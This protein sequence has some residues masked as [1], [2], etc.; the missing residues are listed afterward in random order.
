MEIWT[1]FPKSEVL[2][3]SFRALKKNVSA[4]QNVWFRILR[5]IHSPSRTFFYK[6]GFEDQ[7]HQI[8]PLKAE[9][10][11]LRI[12]YKVS[13]EILTWCWPETTFLFRKFW[14]FF[15]LLDHHTFTAGR[16]WSSLCQ[17][18]RFF[19]FFFKGSHC[20]ALKESHNLVKTSLLFLYYTQDYIHK[21]PYTKSLFAV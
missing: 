10:Y 14:L 18:Q 3:A 12:I 19:F 8:R 17:L 16:A 2:H 11:D 6:I 21:N 7:P 5:D 9:D 1:A 13:W 15:D 20:V 4:Y